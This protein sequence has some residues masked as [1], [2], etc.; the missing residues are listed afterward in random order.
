MMQI[1]KMQILH[2]FLNVTDASRGNTI[3]Q[4]NY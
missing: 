1:L 3:K 2:I 4:G